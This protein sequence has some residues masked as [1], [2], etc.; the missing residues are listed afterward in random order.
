MDSNEERHLVDSL[1]LSVVN[2]G[3]TYEARKAI[4]RS[5]EAWKERVKAMTQIVRERAHWETR[6]FGTKFPGNVIQ[7]AGI[8]VHTYMTKHVK[9]LDKPT[10]DPRIAAYIK[11]LG[12]NSIVNYS[13]NTLSCLYST[14]GENV[15][16]GLLDRYFAEL[17]KWS[18]LP[19]ED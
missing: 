12:T 18:G 16:R 19:K 15:V 5:G 14:H 7:Y 17:R 3:R 9:E 10:P 2:D 4:M 8:E 6:T 13:H 11:E 1:V